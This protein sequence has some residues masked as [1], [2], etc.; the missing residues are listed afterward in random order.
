M[1]KIR[2]FLKKLLLSPSS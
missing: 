2:Y 1:L